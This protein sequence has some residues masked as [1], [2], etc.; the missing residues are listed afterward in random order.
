MPSEWERERERERE[1]EKYGVGGW[2]GQRI[3]REK[4]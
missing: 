3:K 1:R 4:F 2:F